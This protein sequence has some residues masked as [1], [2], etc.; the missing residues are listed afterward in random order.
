ML[1]SLPSTTEAAFAAYLTANYS[2]SYPVIRAFST[3][4]LTVPFIMVKAAD[5]KQVEPETHLYTAK[6]VISVAT[7]IDDITDPLTVHDNT[8]AD[9]Y[10]FLANKAALSASANAPGNNFQLI[11]ADIVSFDQDRLQEQRAFLSL[12]E[13]EL[14]CQTLEL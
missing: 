8:V 7:Q 10:G 13:L 5:F 11:N 3:G 9:V 1:Y 4:D 12:I 6:C 2:G 14:Y